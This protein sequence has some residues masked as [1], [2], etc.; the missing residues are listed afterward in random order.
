MLVQST[1]T[2]G[3]PR[4]LWTICCNLGQASSAPGHNRGPHPPPPCPKKRVNMTGLLQ[5]V[6]QTLRKPSTSESRFATMKCLFA[7]FHLLQPDTLCQVQACSSCLASAVMV[8]LKLCRSR[9]M[10]VG[11]AYQSLP[12]RGLQHISMSLFSLPGPD[13]K[14]ATS[15]DK[16][17]QYVFKTVTIVDGTSATCL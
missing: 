16:N 11:S 10:T 1:R 15:M 9:Q 4:R 7:L 14:Q 12:L 17:L 2:L 13:R 6:F 5:V 3:L 8:H